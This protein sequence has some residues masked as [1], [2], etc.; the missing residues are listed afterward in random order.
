MRV[1]RQILSAACRGPGLLVP[2]LLAFALSGCSKAAIE[3]Q[4]VPASELWPRWAV[5]DESATATIDHNAWDELLRSHLEPGPQGVNRFAYGRV[6]GDDKAKLHAYIAALSEIPI[7]RYRRAEQYAY[8]V[9]LY[10]AVTVRV[11]L[12]EY[13]V[14]SIRDINDGLLSPGPW[15]RQL[16]TV[17]GEAVT[18]N[19]IESRILRPIWNDPRTHYALNCAS[20]GCPNLRRRAFT[21]AS[22]E[23][24]L[25]QA[26]RDYINNPRGV[27]PG[28][29]G[30]QLSSIYIW[31]RDD[32]GGSE[33]TVL[34]HLRR[35][36]EPGLA[37][38]LHE[39]AE[40]D[41]YDYDWALN[42]PPASLH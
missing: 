37:A 23:A 3:A 26:A 11:V 41:G 33:A 8:W 6:G 42:E 12:A 36:A 25:E 15:D 40:I 19:D 4:F 21:A 7:S 27:R 31:F 17:E 5:H 20:V 28:E 24:M 10:N 32:F 9:N 34:A 13:P 14:A 1:V 29:D 2:A 16:V 30:L 18:L 38:E 39:G 35:Y 22:T